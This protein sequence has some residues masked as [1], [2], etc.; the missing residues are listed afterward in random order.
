MIRIVGI[1]P[2]ILAFISEQTFYKY[3]KIEEKGAIGANLMVDLD[4]F[5]LGNTTSI[6][7]T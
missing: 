2:C 3:G 5:L 4:I 6:L 7:V 1:L